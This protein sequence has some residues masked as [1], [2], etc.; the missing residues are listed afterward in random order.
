MQAGFDEFPTRVTVHDAT[1]RQASAHVHT[2]GAARRETAGHSMFSSSEN[3]PRGRVAAGFRESRAPEGG[4]PV[5]GRK[6]AAG[7]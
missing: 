7:H 5:E 4:D 2:T 1:A 6:V 3:S